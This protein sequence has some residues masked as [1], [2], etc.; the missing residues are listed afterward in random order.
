MHS[1][2]EDVVKTGYD[3]EKAAKRR[4]AES[5]SNILPGLVIAV[6]AR[7]SDHTAMVS[8]ETSYVPPTFS[9]NIWKTAIAPKHTE[10]KTLTISVFLKKKKEKQ[11]YTDN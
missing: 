6:V 8:Q 7:W 1:G 11:R 4:K 9:F 2:L 10:N 3:T 5:L